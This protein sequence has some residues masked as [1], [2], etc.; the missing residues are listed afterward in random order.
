VGRLGTSKKGYVTL[1]EFSSPKRVF[2]PNSLLSGLCGVGVLL[3]PY[4]SIMAAE[5]S[6]AIMSINGIPYGGDYLLAASGT[7]KKS[8]HVRSK[9]RI[10]HRDS[11]AVA[12]STVQQDSLATTNIMMQLDS[13]AA[14]SGTAQQD[15]FAA[16]NNTIQQDSLASAGSTAQQES[17]SIKTDTSSS[18]SLSLKRKIENNGLTNIV[19]TDKSIR[20]YGWGEYRVMGRCLCCDNALDGDCILV[21]NTNRTDRVRIKQVVDGKVLADTNDNSTFFGDVMERENPVPVSE[22][23]IEITSKKMRNIYAVLVYTM[24]DKEKKKNFLSNFEL[25]YYDQFDRLQWAGKAECQW[26]DKWNKYHIAFEMEK[27]IFTKSILLKVKGG[28]NRI[29]EVALFG[30]TD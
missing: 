16:T 13:L 27:P 4:F 1:K 2:K 8:S 6:P 24:I 15:S 19:L 25:G 26:N 21:Q 22:I 29:T 11:L 20:A 5:D 3:F 18:D 23:M 14:A 10:R 9:K 28:K 17:F 12:G 30:K 7:A